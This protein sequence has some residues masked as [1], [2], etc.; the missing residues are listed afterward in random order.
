MADTKVDTSSE[1][2]AKVMQLQLYIDLKMLRFINLNK[3]TNVI[4]NMEFAMEIGIQHYWNTV[5]ELCRCFDLST[6][7]LKTFRGW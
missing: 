4:W 2:S 1:V 3:Q 5:C 6:V 7:T